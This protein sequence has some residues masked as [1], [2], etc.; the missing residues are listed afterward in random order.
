MRSKAKRL[1]SSK[2]A[3]A[4]RK[5]IDHVVRMTMMEAELDV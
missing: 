5:S 1:T 3:A 4:G 2:M